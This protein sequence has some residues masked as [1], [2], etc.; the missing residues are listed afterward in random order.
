MLHITA[1][2]NLCIVVVSAQLFHCQLRPQ[3]RLAGVA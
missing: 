2:E 3:Q 1:K